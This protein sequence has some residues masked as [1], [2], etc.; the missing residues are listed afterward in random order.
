MLPFRGRV[1]GIAYVESPALL[2]LLESMDWHEDFAWWDDTDRPDGISLQ[3]WDERG[4]I[5][6]EL[7]AQDPYGRPAGCGFGFDVECLAKAPD[8]IEVVER[9][10]SFE[11]RVCRQ[12]ELLALAERVRSFKGEDEWEGI[13]EGLRWLATDEGKEALAAQKRRIAP[14]LKRSLEVQDLYGPSPEPEACQ[15]SPAR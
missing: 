9:Q 14:V 6:K 4:R 1:Y 5:W 7:L 15:P 13:F 8:P 11:D 2:S 12:A 10:P 3:D